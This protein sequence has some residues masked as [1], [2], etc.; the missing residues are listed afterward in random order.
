MRRGPGGK[1]I[2]T[3][4]GVQNLQVISPKV[5]DCTFATSIMYGYGRSAPEYARNIVFS[6]VQAIRCGIAFYVY[7]RDTSGGTVE[8]INHD[9]AT[10]S[11]VWT[12]SAWCCGHHPDFFEHDNTPKAKRKS[13]A[14]TLAGSANIFVDAVVNNPALYPSAEYPAGGTRFPTGYPSDD[15][16]GVEWR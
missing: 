10:A 12:G 6:D 5:E 15:P 4:D 3:E 14:I 2:C 16:T 13:A 7:G 11:I 1:G 9:P 8:E